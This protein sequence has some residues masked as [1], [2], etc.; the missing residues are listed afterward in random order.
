MRIHYWGVRGAIPT[1]GPG[2]VE[3]GGNTPC[4]EVR[5]ADNRLIIIDAGSGIRRLGI[6]L[7]EELP[8]RIEG[9]ILISHTYWDHIQ[10]FPFFA[11]L[12][13][14]NRRENYFLVIG[15]KRVGRQLCS[16]E[17]SVPN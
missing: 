8:E 3:L 6:T 2:T 10:G 15:Q 9:T 4:V 5:T 7:I 14:K 11:S 1:P 17:Q 12:V 16:F 13:G